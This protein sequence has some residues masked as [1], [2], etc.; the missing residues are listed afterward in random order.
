MKRTI[1][2]VISV[3]LVL[4][5]AGCSLWPQGPPSVSRT[6]DE[7]SGPLR[8]W[9]A[10]ANSSLDIFDEF[11]SETGIQ[12]K[13]EFD[14]QKAWWE[15]VLAQKGN[16]EADLFW[17]DNA[18]DL[19]ALAGLGAF[20]AYVSP[21]ASSLP[22]HA[23]DRDGLW[24]GLTVRQ[25]VLVY[26]V[27]ALPLDVPVT[28]EQLVDTNWQMPLTVPVASS[29]LW[30]R[31]LVDMVVYEGEMSLPSFFEKLDAVPLTY[32]E[33]PQ[34]DVRHVAEGTIPLLLTTSE[35]ALKF[36]AE[37]EKESQNMRVQPLGSKYTEQLDLVT[38]IGILRGTEKKE[39]AGQLIDFLLEEKR[40]EALAE[41]LFHFPLMDDASGE[42]LH[43]DEMVRLLPLIERHWLQRE[44]EQS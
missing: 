24:H 2:T 15:K 4:L 28:V 30:D 3:C 1:T 44:N 29:R 25:M 11:T 38:G 9:V 19:A 17:S 43:P 16:P 12:V 42:R 32:S 23:R 5:V 21:F 14:S 8:V 35:S 6:D 40:R 10:G 7:G 33:S 18:L 39:T 41:Q 13:V 20:E 37:N 31:F 36:M 22:G 26:D 34:E 27:H